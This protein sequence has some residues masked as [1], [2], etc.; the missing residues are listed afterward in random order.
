MKQFYYLYFLV[1]VMFSLSFNDLVAGTPGVVDGEG[2]D[3]EGVLIGKGE[4]GKGFVSPEL[5]EL[6]M[7]G[8]IY[9]VDSHS[10][11]LGK[12][13]PDGSLSWEIDGRE[14]GGN[15]FLSPASIGVSSGLYIYLLDTGRRE[16]FQI[17]KSGEILGKITEESLKDPR[18][19]VLTDAGKLAVFDASTAEVTV[20]APSGSILWSFRPEGF[21]SRSNIGMVVSNE[22]ELCLF[23]RGSKTLR[24][25]HFMGG[26]KRVWKP[27]LPDGT[28]LKV[29]SVD[30]DREG[31]A[32]VLDSDIPGLFVFDRLGNLLLDMRE[33]LTRLEYKGPGEVRKMGEAVYIADVRGGKVFELK[34]LPRLF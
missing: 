11:R 3:Y 8:N 28:K 6:D 26:L 32:F 19:L 18:A 2:K 29:S 15:G 4:D 17:N 33:S 20:L 7:E 9:V 14:W 27:T 16:I 12:F 34:I 22:E 24:M 25:Y 1:S 23:T 10:A 21:R 30:F 5:I 31:R 13:G